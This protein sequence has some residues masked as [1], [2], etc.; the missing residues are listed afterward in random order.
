MDP[1]YAL[2]VNRM[3]EK[4]FDEAAPCRWCVYPR[5]TVVL[6]EATVPAA[7]L[8]AEAQLFMRQNGSVYPGSPS[9]DFD[10]VPLNNGWLVN[11][12]APKQGTTFFGVL[13]D[14]TYSAYTA[15]FAQR[16]AREKDALCFPV[17]TSSNFVERCRS[18]KYSSAPHTD[19]TYSIGSDSSADY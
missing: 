17:C 9:G 4:L 3:I 16:Q 18:P 15:G 19:F 14:S 6:F 10:P 1:S 12:E 11:F 13:L 7:S 8:V 5:G 2:R